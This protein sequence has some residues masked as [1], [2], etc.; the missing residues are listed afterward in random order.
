MLPPGHIAGGFLTAYGIIKLTH[1]QL[2]PSQI[3]H[4]FWFGVVFG[5]LPDMDM[6]VWFFK[7][8]SFYPN[9]TREDNHRQSIFHYPLVWLLAGIAIYFLSAT[10]YGKTAG[11]IVWLASWSHFVLDSIE[12]GIRWLWPFSSKFY[13]LK[14]RTHEDFGNVG[15]FRHWYRFVKNYFKRASFYLEIIVILTALIIYFKF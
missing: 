12:F 14:S 13:A 10:A 4:L 1:P 5:F 15:F 11:L 8:K 2:A 9:A 3:N 6:F 7:R